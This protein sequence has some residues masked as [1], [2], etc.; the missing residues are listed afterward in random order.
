LFGGER[1][2]TES[3]SNI[4]TTTLCWANLGMVEDPDE[5]QRIAKQLAEEWLTRECGELTPTRLAAKI[6]ASYGK[7]H[8]FAVPILTTCAFAGM[9]G[10][11]QHSWRLVP[12]LP[13]EFAACPHRWL[14][15]LRL[16]T[17]SYA[18][19]AL[20][21][22]GQAR[23]HHR[24][25]RNP[26]LRLLRNLT[27]RRTLR[28]LEQIQPTSGGYLEAAP[29]TSFVSMSLIS[30]GMDRHP[31]VIAGLGFLARGQRQDG[32][33]AIDSN[34]DT[35]LTTLAVD[36][37]ASADDDQ[38]HTL[39]WLLDQQYLVEHPFTHAAP[40]GWAWTDLS[41]GV[42]D[43]DD[44]A[45]ALIAVGH[46]SRDLS[47]HDRDRS[48]IATRRGIGWL[49]DL[50]NRDGGIPTFCRGWGALPFDRSSQDITAHALRAFA[51]FDGDSSDA[52]HERLAKATAAGI[53]YL[54]R[55][56]RNDGAWLP[57][58]FGN[59]DD[60]RHENPI[61]GTARVLRAAVE[62][63]AA[64]NLEQSWVAAGRR[65][66]GWLLSVQR[67]DGS[68]V[69]STGGKA[70]IEETA[71]ALEALAAW[72]L[73]EREGSIPQNSG[74][75]L[76]TAIEAGAMWLA[77]ET[78]GGTR[79]DT[80]PIGLYFAKLWYSERLYPLIFTVSALKLA[81]RCLA[82]PSIANP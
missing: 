30:M 34:L 31:V 37:L 10:E 70:C 66:L 41:G 24:P 3:P 50:Q 15:R 12:A 60:P 62:V 29:L 65:G 36:A 44:T 14:H 68:F 40:G 20:I 5:R 8:T 6:R 52:V 18:L 27:R 32:S 64:T 54:Q 9:L 33:W 53:R 22:I 35:W 13:F 19:P 75:E 45:G 61:Y 42:P 2:T 11:W 47:N 58:W 38:S 23:H 51:A 25:T 56:Q 69:A 71:L 80:A 81:R 55:E 49:L 1:A 72:L 46:L 67:N 63:R 4:S 17:V 43:A 57:L 28:I 21:A 16:D 26:L 79:F 39:D 82:V 76:T 7:D 78:E 59:Q 73:A 77:R 74:S 48:R